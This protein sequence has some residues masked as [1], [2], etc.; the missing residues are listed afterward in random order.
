MPCR[1]ACASGSPGARSTAA[2][3]APRRSCRLRR[4]TAPFPAAS[5]RGLAG[6]RGGGEIPDGLPLTVSARSWSA[7]AFIRPRDPSDWM[8]GTAWW[9]KALWELLLGSV[10]SSPELF[11]DDTACRC[12]R[13]ARAGRGPAISG[14]SPGTTVPG[15]ATCRRRWPTS[16]PRTGSGTAPARC[17]PTTPACSRSTAGAASS[18]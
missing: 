5:D 16:T 8:G 10:L 11:C 12:S 17:W 7:T 15:G 4:R 3:A 9:L 1:C 13:P 2:G 14:A 18:G 6:P